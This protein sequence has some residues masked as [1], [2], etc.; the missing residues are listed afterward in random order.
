[1]AFFA[2][3]TILRFP[4]QFLGFL[5]SFTLDALSA[6]ARFKEV[7][8][9]PVTVADPADPVEPTSADGGARLEFRNVTFRFDDQGP[10]DAPLFSGL[11]LN[12]AP[13][14]RMALVGLTGSGKSTLLNLAARFYD[15]TAGCI[16]IDGADI[17]DLTRK[18]LRQQ[19]AV[20]LEEPTL[21]SASVR[22]NVL[23][24]NPGA[25][26]DV[27]ATALRVAAADFVD[28]LRDGVDTVIGEEGQS[29]SGGQRQRLALARAIA[30][31]P[32][33]M[34][35]DDPLSALDVHTEARVT[36]ELD[37]A[38]GDTTVLIVAQRPSTVALAHRVALLDRGQVVAI[39][40]HEELLATN[41]RYRYVIS[42]FADERDAA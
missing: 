8:D 4:L 36:A 16:L 22:D 24:G 39:G 13:G 2:T 6:T 18:R 12:V 14:E 7:M 23:L 25:S 1:M 21:F 28:A 38:L 11:D 32:R 42:S 5:I 19:L 9:A 37:R 35:L 41:D 15:V 10:G 29:L 33:L 17:R 27:V 3:A 40:T 30:S 20:A 26:D 34:L 31:Q